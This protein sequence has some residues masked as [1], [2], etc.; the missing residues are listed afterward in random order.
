MRSCALVRMLPGA[1][2]IMTASANATQV[3]ILSFFPSGVKLP[4]INSL[5]GR[6][7]AFHRQ[8]VG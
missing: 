8:K 1:S 2:A 3:V 6:K 5:I 7:P 4:Q